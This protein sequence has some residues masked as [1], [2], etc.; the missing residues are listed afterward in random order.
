MNESLRRMDHL[1]YATPNLEHSIADLEGRLGVR[2]VIGGQHPGRGT[3]NALLALSDSSYLELIGP[4]TTQPAADR[5]PWFAMDHL[6]EPRLLTWAV[7]ERALD[8]LKSK[9]EAHGV[10]LGPV[11]AGHRQ[12]ADGTDLRW[13]FT[14]PTT[15][16]A[17]GLVPFF[18][19][20]GDSPHPAASA[21]PGLVLDSLRAEHPQPTAV[22]HALSAVGIDLL[23][24]R[25]SRPVLIASLRT[26]RGIV[27]L[28]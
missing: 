15:V 16:V 10:H 5:P 25:G 18:I 11:E 14:D 20:W 27:E 28:R 19:D 4:D 9:A 13:R 8:E 12:R 26:Q 6:R 7:K 24:E 2:P 17:D 3:R 23:V 1:V 21:P 22:R